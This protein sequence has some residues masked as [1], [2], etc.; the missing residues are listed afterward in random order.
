MSELQSPPGYGSIVPFDKSKHRG[1][2]VNQSGL[3]AFAAPL[4][5]VYI[6]LV[7]FQQAARD[8][9]IVF[10]GDSAGERLYPFI[11]TGL[12]SGQNLYVGK[13]GVWQE[14][15]YVPAY[16]RR[17][18]FCTV[19]IRQSDDKDAP[20]TQMICVDEA[21]LTKE[22]PELVTGEGDMSDIWP[23]VET[24]IKE[25]DQASLATP[26]FME[27]LKEHDLLEKVEAHI[28]EKSGR[29]V[30]LQGM[31]RISQAKLKKLS[32]EVLRDL[33][34]KDYLYHIDL[35]RMS[36]DNFRGLLDRAMEDSTD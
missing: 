29:E 16:V 23:P 32:D 2:G 20:V 33:L 21:G 25:V 15:T 11:V 28:H 9:P 17:Y 36:L 22:A 27:A 5:S 18:P 6:T 35:H 24:F 14:K 3:F 30:R 34:E 1:L 12:E 4:N 26:R 8:Y 19:N 13:D 31:Y 10:A 7:E